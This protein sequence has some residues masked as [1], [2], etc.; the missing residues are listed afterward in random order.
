MN[1]TKQ[2]IVSF[3]ITQRGEHTQW[4]DEVLSSGLR[5]GETLDSLCITELKGIENELG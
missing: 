4:I 1:E 5:D 3:L 2:Y